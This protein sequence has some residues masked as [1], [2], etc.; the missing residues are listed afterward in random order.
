MMQQFLYKPGG[1]PLLGGG[2]G[3]PAGARGMSPSPAGAPEFHNFADNA[4]AAM[5]RAS[6]GSAAGLP[7]PQ[8]PAQQKVRA[9]RACLVCSSM[10]P[11]ARRLSPA[12]TLRERC[13]LESSAQG[14]RCYSPA[15]RFGMYGSHSCPLFH[16]EGR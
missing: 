16:F 11:L 4:L 10:R 5:S 2:L 14:G 12:A 13:R 1:A 8:P 7:A 3:A 15:M 9:R 6:S